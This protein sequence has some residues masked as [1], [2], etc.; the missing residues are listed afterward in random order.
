[1][2]YGSADIEING[3]P[4]NADADYVNAQGNKGHTLLGIVG[5]ETGL[6]VSSRIRLSAEQRFH[7]RN[8]HYDYLPRVETKS[9]ENLLKLAYTL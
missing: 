4:D 2:G 6:R 3:L 7:F 8:S 5:I 1:R 9:T